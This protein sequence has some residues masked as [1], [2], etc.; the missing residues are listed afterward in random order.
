MRECVFSAPRSRR[1]PGRRERG[2]AR[3]GRRGGA[4]SRGQGGPGVTAGE[5][6]KSAFPISSPLFPPAPVSFFS[7]KLLGVN[8]VFFLL[9]KM[10]PASRGG[11]ERVGKEAAAA[12]G[13]IFHPGFLL[14][15]ASAGSHGGQSSGPIARP[16]PVPGWVLRASL[17]AGLPVPRSIVP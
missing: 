7:W 1:E 12:T 10:D 4:A 3:G 13:F 11:G 15:A 2:S 17:L 16:N 9:G 6:E 5:E 14:P 8:R